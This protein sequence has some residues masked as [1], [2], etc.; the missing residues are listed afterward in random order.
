VIN[1]VNVHRSYNGVKALD[2]LSL[3]VADGVMMGIM[4]PGGCGK[5]TLCK[6]I[7]GLLKP[8]SGVVFVERVDMLKA[9]PREIKAVQSRFGVQ[10][11]NDALF[12]HMTV[13]ENVE[14]PLRRLTDFSENQIRYKATEI[15]AVVGLSGMEHRAPNELSG[16]QRRRVAIA[17]ACV[18][19]P[20]LLICDDPTAG[21][22]PVTSRQILDMI[23]GIHYQA[24]NTVLVVSSDVLG[25]L[26]VIDRA[27]LMWDG[28]VI[29]EG[30]PPIIWN[31]RRRHVRR[32]FDD[33]RLPE[34]IRTPSGV[35]KWDW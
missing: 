19:E 17:R 21:L 16:G 9:K 18:T 33:A 34:S 5:S 14:Y 15:L 7:S 27:A 32:F 6:V 25:L 35:V 30:T 8:D 4:G 13:L 11:Q 23:V 10:F 22:D 20:D 2:G 28:K 26:S 1:L 31:D 24:K 3:M 12:E 29:A